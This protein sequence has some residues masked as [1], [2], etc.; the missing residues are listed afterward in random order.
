MPKRFALIIAS[1]LL[2]PL[3]VAHAAKLCKSTMSAE[4]NLWPTK[5]VAQA[6]A[7]TAWQTRVTA[8]D[9]LIYANWVN[10]D[11]KQVDCKMTTSPVGANTW[12]CTVTAKPCILQ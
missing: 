3:P 8:R 11:A 6:S 12:S 10:A 1:V 5:A 9:G 7:T 2:A 4:A